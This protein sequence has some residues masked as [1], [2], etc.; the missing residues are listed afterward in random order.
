MRSLL[1]LCLLPILLYA[2]VPPDPA[3]SDPA[4]KKGDSITEPESAKEQGGEPVP[5]IKGGEMGK[6]DYVTIG[7]D[8]WCVDNHFPG[9]AEAK[10]A[11]HQAVIDTAGASQEWLDLVQRDLEAEGLTDPMTTKIAELAATRCPGGVLP[12][13]LGDPPPA[14]VAPEPADAPAETPADADAPE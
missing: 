5:D 9:D 3:G 4:G 14:A 8:L 6:E 2:C 7:A 10:A 1:P 13:G 12:A 11:A